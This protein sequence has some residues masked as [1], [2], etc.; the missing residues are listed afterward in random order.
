MLLNFFYRCFKVRSKTFR[1]LLLLLC[2][3]SLIGLLV[4]HKDRIVHG[5]YPNQAQ[6]KRYSLYVE[7]ELKKQL[8]S[9]QRL[10]PTR[11]FTG[12][13][14]MTNKT[15]SLLKIDPDSKNVTTHSKAQTAKP[16]NVPTQPPHKVTK[17]PAPPNTA[18]KVKITI[19]VKRLTG[20]VTIASRSLLNMTKVT[21]RTTTFV[22]INY[23]GDKYARDDTH[24]NS[25]CP[26]RTTDKLRSKE[27]E[28]LFVESVPVLQ[29]KKH[30]QESEYV[31][32]RK[33]NGAQG[34]KV[35]P[36]QI[37]NESLNLLN[38]TGN[39]YMF[40]NWKGQSQCIRCAVVGNGGILNGSGM[41]KEI[42]AHDYVFRVNGAIT[43]DYEQDVGART[44]FYFFST[45][46]L[47]NSLYAYNDRGFKKLPRTE[48]TRYVVLPD[49][50]RD[51]LIVRAALT[52][53]TVDQGK[54]KGKDPAKYFGPNLTTEHFKILHPDF[55]RY[56]RNRKH[57]LKYEKC[58]IWWMTNVPPRR[59]TAGLILR[60]HP[61]MWVK[62]T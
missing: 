8:E 9:N 3:V 46:T 42:D 31:R 35:V 53:T 2:L 25:K 18:A 32:L 48:E 45:N 12:T 36:W 38:S 27:F 56:I 50:D 54:D 55:M 20:N 58:H 5:I 40:D 57:E 39:G 22:Y 34:W 23:L 61:K 47:F 44:S 26:N 21:V 7:E 24:V 28:E 16:A 60:L 19:P 13:A 51:Y 4:S 1:K 10:S 14:K 52:N 29:W 15:Q 49:H 41:G 11:L 43:T 17:R 6:H 62:R 30:A 59:V 33:Y 37:L